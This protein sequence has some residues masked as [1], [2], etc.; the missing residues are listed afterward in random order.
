MITLR[1]R[2]TH[3][4]AAIT[5]PPRCAA[6]ADAAADADADATILLDAFDAAATMLRCRAAL[7][8]RCA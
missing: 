4:R 6:A 5:M 7:I 2:Y 8:C 3:F 1:Q